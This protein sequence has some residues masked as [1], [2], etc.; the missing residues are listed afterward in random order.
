VALNLESLEGRKT[1]K[2][3]DLVACFKILKGITSTALHAASFSHCLA[4]VLLVGILL[5]YIVL[6][7]G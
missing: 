7:Q 1:D 5:S 4:A 6:I 2:K 3:N